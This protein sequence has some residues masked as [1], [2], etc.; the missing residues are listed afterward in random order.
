MIANAKIIVNNH[1]GLDAVPSEL[2]AMT[3]LTSFP[4]MV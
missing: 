2:A 1:A 3:L 4:L